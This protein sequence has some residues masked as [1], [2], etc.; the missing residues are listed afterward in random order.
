MTR[1]ASPSQHPRIKQIDV[2][3]D[4]Q[5]VQPGWEPFYLGA[6]IKGTSQ[7]LHRYNFSTWKD[8]VYDALALAAVVDYCDR[9]TRR[10]TPTWGRSFKLRF[11]VHDAQ[12]WLRHEVRAAL[13]DALTFLTGDSWHITFIQR[14]HQIERPRESLLAFDYPQ[15]LSVIPFSNGM[16]SHLVAYLLGRDESVV[17]MRIGNATGEAKTRARQGE[18]FVAIPFE[19]VM[20]G[21]PRRDSSGQSRGFT[22]ALM[23][24]LFAYLD[25]AQSVVVPESGQGALGPAL[26]PLGQIARDHR[27]HPAFTRRI[28]LFLSAL[29][30]TE[31]RYLHPRIWHT[32]AET[33]REYLQN[34]GGDS[35]RETRSCW[36]DARWVSTGQCGV[37]AACLLRRMSV[38]AAGQIESPELYAWPNLA[39]STLQEAAADG[40]P[41]EKTNR[42]VLEYAIAGIQHLDHLARLRHDPA[43]APAL[44]LAAFQLAQAL[45]LPE[46]EAKVKLDR[47]LA[48]HEGEYTTFMDSLTPGSFLARYVSRRQ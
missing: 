1:K 6:N 18:E 48:T 40:L 43:D 30:E 23:T 32:K 35:W 17:R 7:S 41:P 45:E 9:S 38:H 3:E 21:T 47:M 8:E 36:R 39:A 22:F 44:E 28:R 4:G 11:P 5:T 2:L 31:I 26:A 13:I 25:G 19:P 10:P 15:R 33:L 29:L 12:R 37:C 24:G 27:S 34:N 46:E 16:D 42:A 14:R 20:K